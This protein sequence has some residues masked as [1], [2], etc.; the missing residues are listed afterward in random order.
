MSVSLRSLDDAWLVVTGQDVGMFDGLAGCDP[1]D[2]VPKAGLELVA[3]EASRKTDITS[4]KNL[5]WY[6]F[7]HIWIT[8]ALER[9]VLIATV[10]HNC[11]TSTSSSRSTTSTTTQRER[12]M[13]LKLSWT[14][15]RRHWDR[16]EMR[17][18]R[19]LFMT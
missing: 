8:F 15:Q 19:P 12:P 5:T 2:A 18:I 4:G 1:K 3:I 17:P 16:L 10:C 7:R 11:D 6:S 9:G 14:T 13:H